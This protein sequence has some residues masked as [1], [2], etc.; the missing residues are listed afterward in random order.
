MERVNIDSD[1]NLLLHESQAQTKQHQLSLLFHTSNQLKFTEWGNKEKSPRILHTNQI[2]KY[3][4][5]HRYQTALE[6]FADLSALKA[7]I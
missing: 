4:F 5:Y 7:I 6:V 2:I 3:M 1:V